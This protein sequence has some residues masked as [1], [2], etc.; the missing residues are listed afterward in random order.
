MQRLFFNKTG[1]ARD[2]R[3]KIILLAVFTFPLFLEGCGGESTTP[4][5]GTWQAVYPALSSASTVTDTKTVY[6]DNPPVALTVKNST[7]TGTFVATCT[8]TIIT[9]STDPVTGQV[10]TTS[11]PYPP[12][13]TY[14]NFSVSFEAKSNAPD[15]LHAIVNGVAF[16]G[17]CIST[18]AC[19]AASGAGDT[20]G[21]T[22]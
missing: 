12:T 22:R 18:V 4:Y 13:A 7:G 9:K 8:T 19:S 14:A 5:D 17:Q 16:T 10:T 2:M 21:L 6:C 1:S 3:S 11:T 15:V 20:L